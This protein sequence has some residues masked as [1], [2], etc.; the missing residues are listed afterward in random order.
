MANEKE[1][2]EFKEIKEPQDKKLA[3]GADELQQM[4]NTLA[5]ALIDSKKPYVDPGQAENDRMF[6]ESTRKNEENKRAM[7]KAGQS[8]CPH[9]QGCHEL[10]AE[11]GNRTS[12]VQHRFDNNLVIGICTNCQRVFKPGDADYME[13]MQKKS[14]NIPSG[15]GLRMTFNPSSKLESN[16]AT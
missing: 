4:F 1:V 11:A 12:I 15:S 2:K 7:I 10:S 8:R 9:L 13:W 5:A 3:I 6:A 14:G 16:F